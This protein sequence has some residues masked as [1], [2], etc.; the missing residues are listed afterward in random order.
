M[1]RYNPKNKYGNKKTK[2]YDSKKESKRAGEL[3][4]LEK[5][6]EI[7]E[8]KE[9]VSFELQP[10]FQTKKGNIIRPIT[11]IAD[12]KYFDCEKD[13]WVVEDV[14]GFKTDHYRIK[15]KLFQFKYPDYLFIE[16]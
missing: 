6:G 4:L 2:G 13:C 12:F 7:R 8:L 5:A 1:F 3:K 11:Y 9:Q 16:S 15:A 14:K 10:R